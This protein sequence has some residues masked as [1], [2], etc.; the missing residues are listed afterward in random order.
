MKE[1]EHYQR[2][3]ILESTNLLTHRI[4]VDLCQMRIEA[5]ENAEV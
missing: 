5:L 1:R 2:V 4:V 3:V